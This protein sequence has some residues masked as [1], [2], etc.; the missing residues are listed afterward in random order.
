MTR[1]APERPR[2]GGKRGG[3]LSGANKR[4]VDDWRARAKKEREQATR[5]AA[6][7]RQNRPRGQ[8]KH[9]R[10]A[11][12]A[13]A[14]SEHRTGQG[15]R[16]SMNRRNARRARAAAAKE[17]DPARTRRPARAGE[18]L[19]VAKPVVGIVLRAN[20][21]GGPQTQRANKKVLSVPELEGDDSLKMNAK[22]FVKE[23]LVHLTHCGGAVLES[24]AAHFVKGATTKDAL[25]TLFSMDP[26]DAVL[27]A[28]AAEEALR[29]KEDLRVVSGNLKWSA[30]GVDACGEI[31]RGD[32]EHWLL[33]QYG[34][35]LS[36][37]RAAYA[38]LR[39][40]QRLWRDTMEAYMPKLLGPGA[41]GVRRRINNKAAEV[42]RAIRDQDDRAVDEDAFFT[43]EWLEVLSGDMRD[44][45]F[46]RVAL[47]L[48]TARRRRGEL[49]CVYIRRLIELKKRAEHS[50]PALLA[51]WP[52]GYF[53]ERVELNL[54]RGEKKLLRRLSGEALEFPLTTRRDSLASLLASATAIEGQAT[55][56][57]EP[58]VMS[59]ELWS[60]QIN[61]RR[62][63]LGIM[64]EAKERFRKKTRTADGL[65]A[66]LVRAHA[67][68]SARSRVPAKAVLKKFPRFHYPRGG[69]HQGGK[70]RG[71]VRRAVAHTQ[72]RLCAASA[73]GERCQKKGC[74]FRHHAG[75][76]AAKRSHGGKAEWPT[77]QKRL[78]RKAATARVGIAQCRTGSAV[79]DA[80]VTGATSEVEAAA[81]AAVADPDAEEGADAVTVTYGSDD[82][83]SPE[84]ADVKDAE[85]TAATADSNDEAG[86]TIYENGC[87]RIGAEAFEEMTTRIQH[88]LCAINETEQEAETS[89]AVTA[90]ATARRARAHYGPDE[91]DAK[92]AS[93]PKAPEANLPQTR[94]DC[95]NPF[96]ML[97]S[98]SE[99]EDE[100]DAEDQK[101]TAD[102]LEELLPTNGDVKS[103][104]H[105][106]ADLF[107]NWAAAIDAK[108][109]PTEKLGQQHN[110]FRLC[111]NALCTAVIPAA[112]QV[113]TQVPG[114]EAPCHGNCVQDQELPWHP[115]PTV[116][117]EPEH[118]RRSI[119]TGRESHRICEVEG[120]TATVTGR[121]HRCPPPIHP[122]DVKGLQRR[123]RQR[124]LREAEKS[125]PSPPADTE[126]TYVE[127]QALQEQRDPRLF[128]PHANA[129]SCDAFDVAAANI[130]N[131][132]HESDVDPTTLMDVWSP[133][134]EEAGNEMLEVDATQDMLAVTDAMKEVAGQVQSA[135]LAVEEVAIRLQAKVAAA[136]GTAAEKK[137]E[138]VGDGTT[139]ELEEYNSVYENPVDWSY[140]QQV[141]PQLNSSPLVRFGV[142]VWSV[143]K[144][145]WYD[146]GLIIHVRYDET[147]ATGLMKLVYNLRDS[148]GHLWKT[149]SF[150]D[151]NIVVQLRESDRRSIFSPPPRISELEV[152]G[153]DHASPTYEMMVYIN[154]VAHNET[155]TVL[156][157]PSTWTSNLITE[158]E[159]L[160]APSGEEEADVYLLHMGRPLRKMEA[161]KRRRK[162]RKYKPP[163]P[164]MLLDFGVQDGAVMFAHLRGRG[165][166]EDDVCS[167]E[168]KDGEE[169]PEGQSQAT[170]VSPVAM[171]DLVLVPHANPGSD[172]TNATRAAQ[173][174]WKVQTG[175]SRPTGDEP[176]PEREMER[177]RVEVTELTH[178]INEYRPSI[179]KYFPRGVQNSDTKNV[180][181][182]ILQLCWLRAARI[183][184][185]YRLRRD[186]WKSE[187]QLRDEEIVRLHGLIRTA[188][189]QKAAD[190]KAHEMSY[191]RRGR[192]REGGG[193]P[194]SCH[195]RPPSR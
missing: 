157:T 182:K 98:D 149:V 9:A 173:R 88:G 145:Q 172:I 92:V 114:H 73:R 99:T 164:L 64:A 153:E 72:G 109:H 19:Q 160:C 156:C 134:E 93:L 108:D 68:R 162:G 26:T 67:Q 11:T 192:Q 139:T 132:L 194:R 112:Y 183:Q 119:N 76:S 142:D 84:G 7:R 42:R 83:V 2:G 170:A 104:W 33:V 91:E 110:A 48:L 185:H 37:D 13:P 71:Q 21:V 16:E 189:K 65:D 101:E 184:R 15:L 163:K 175:A 25:Q 186:K 8:F 55:G 151:A 181:L 191:G 126:M 141:R 125:P 30:L 36:Q 45:G 190:T 147:D 169:A 75:L 187:R 146:D 41:A 85:Q 90:P 20:E 12:R 47:A 51:A 63:W 111:G 6:M 82:E 80:A 97:C 127:K 60:I 59:E 77:R 22:G 14:A 58:K 29:R 46:C 178:A 96:E 27:R 52:L 69:N 54:S 103:E 56:K 121:C 123:A 43:S 107:Q 152:K 188:Q 10:R 131:G 171:A 35:A 105:C 165:G 38:A 143:S 124:R 176:Q 32:P 158:A 144:R 24:V 50:E 74:T 168:S 115:L 129:N 159:R 136:I 34:C 40:A 122:R 117:K 133:S 166:G 3:V 148:E 28:A 62:H 53:I 138:H 102:A 49:L 18:H 61:D 39:L 17:Y 86:P 118:Q 174:G 95:S 57:F 87:W 100:E 137:L 120:C 1:G 177:L 113:C 70:Q 154:D 179:H 167:A 193:D 79:F 44:Q 66:H 155:Y 116:K 5:S 23:A 78:G 180:R 81:A 128:V 140:F 135:A 4:P 94:V 31:T 161:P 150:H 89:T 195:A 106:D 130:A